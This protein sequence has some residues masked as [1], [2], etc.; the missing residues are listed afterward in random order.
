MMLLV[1]SHCRTHIHSDGPSI[2]R[3]RVSMQKCNCSVD[4]ICTPCFQECLQVID[5]PEFQRLR[6][7]HQL[8][9]C[10]YVYPSANHT[11]LEHSIGTSHIANE[12]M[13]SLRDNQPE[14]E[15]DRHDMSAVTLAG[16]H[17]NLSFS[18]SLHPAA[19]EADGEC[20]RQTK[21]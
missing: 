8:G 9:L 3:C 10:F 13:K 7:I 21:G 2:H 1:E 17:G 11:R 15:I 14:L 12:L 6:H 16:E 20:V 18:F 19:C 5:T 4:P